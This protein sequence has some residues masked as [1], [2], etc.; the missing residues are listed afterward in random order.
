MSDMNVSNSITGTVGG[1]VVQT[2][3]VG[4]VSFPRTGP[5]S[6]HPVQE[7]PR[8]YSYVALLNDYIRVVNTAGIAH[9]LKQDYYTDET[10]VCGLWAYPL[11][12]DSAEMIRAEIVTSR[13]GVDD[14][15]FIHFTSKIQV[16]GI[17]VDQFGWEVDGRA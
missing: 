14:R 6:A 7:D 10:Q 9:L 11:G 1:A 13:D 8:A 5:A 12:V 4:P 17:T 2:G 15:D 16:A 3:A